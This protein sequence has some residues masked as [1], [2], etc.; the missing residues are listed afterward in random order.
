MYVVVDKFNSPIIQNDGLIKVNTAESTT[1]MIIP[2]DEVSHPLV[3]ATNDE[4]NN[5][6]WILSTTMIS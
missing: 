2:F 5:E 6:L 3:I 1:R 4:L